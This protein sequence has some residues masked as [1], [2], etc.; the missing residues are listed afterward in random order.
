MGCRMFTSASFYCKG[1]CTTHHIKKDDILIQQNITQLRWPCKDVMWQCWASRCSWVFMWVAWRL[2]GRHWPHTSKQLFPFLSRCVLPVFGRIFSSPI[3][4]SKYVW[5]MPKTL[6]TLTS[7]SVFPVT[8]LKCCEVVKWL[9]IISG[10]LHD[11][12][13][14]FRYY[15]QF[16]MLPMHECKVLNKRNTL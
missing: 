3:L 12:G 2:S 8:N 1:T 16:V 13:A 6:C 7:H 14:L 9:W 5:F 15:L 4:Q 10:E 11:T